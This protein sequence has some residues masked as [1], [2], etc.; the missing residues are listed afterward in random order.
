[1]LWSIAPP[2]GSCNDH[3]KP[4]MIMKMLPIAAAL[5]LALLA[6]QGLAASFDCRKASTYAEKAICADPRLSRMDVALA[7]NYRGMLASDFG[8]SPKTLREDQRRWLFQRNQCTTAQCLID[9]Y[10]KRLD[11]T[12]DYGVVSGIHPICTMSEEIP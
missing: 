2:Q 5:A 6:T 7:E 4:E 11:E 12:C 10:R 1:M 8:G 3:P 9:S